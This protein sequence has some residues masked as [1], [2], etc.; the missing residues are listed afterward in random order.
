MAGRGWRA[1]GRSVAVE[2]D[3]DLID[4]VGDRLPPTYR[5]SA[6]TPERTWSVQRSGSAWHVAREGNPFYLAADPVTAGEVLLS[7]MELWVAEHA[8]R[9]VF[10]HA[11]CVVHDGKAI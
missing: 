9:H 8:R 2:G 6:A 4:L 10:I 1:Y 3:T 11:G 7:D 5:S